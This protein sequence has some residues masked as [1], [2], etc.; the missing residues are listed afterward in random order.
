MNFSSS[1]LCFIGMLRKTGNT[2]CAA[3]WIVDSG[4]THHVAQNKNLFEELSD[5][6]NTSVTLPTCFGVKIAGIGRVGL[7]D[8][9][10]LNNVLHIPDFRLNLLSLSQTT[11]DLGY[12]IAFDSDCCMIQDLTKGLIIRKGDQIANLYVLDV[13]D[14]AVSRPL[15]I[16]LLL[17]QM[18]F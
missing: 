1:I 14:I 16:S 2:Q 18:L 4:A 3:S 12:R 13:A 10:V 8:S 11:K 7:S 9:M 17:F 5:A 15:Q 6:M